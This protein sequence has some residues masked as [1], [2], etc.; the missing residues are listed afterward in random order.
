[1][2][3]FIRL[4]IQF[5]VNRIWPFEKDYLSIKIVWNLDFI[6]TWGPGQVPLLPPSP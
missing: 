4:A 2:K 5:K 3:Q 1:L 6:W